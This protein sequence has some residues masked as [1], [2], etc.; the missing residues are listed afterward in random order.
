MPRNVARRSSFAACREKWVASHAPDLGSLARVAT[1]ESEI[2]RLR[3]RN[4]AQRHWRST[5]CSRCSSALRWQLL[6]EADPSV[7]TPATPP[8]A[9]AA[10]VA[11][12]VLREPRHAQLLD[13]EDV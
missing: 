10:A 13:D 5:Q 11:A 3:R 7:W 2:A 4:V 1:S 9:E 12:A 8:S 6:G